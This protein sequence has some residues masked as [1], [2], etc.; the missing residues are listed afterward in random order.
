MSK[1]LRFILPCLAL[2]LAVFVEAQPDVPSA[3]T[4]KRMIN[5]MNRLSEFGND[6]AYKVGKK[7]NLPND[8]MQEVEITTSMLST[9]PDGNASS[10]PTV[11][12]SVRGRHHIPFTL[13]DGGISP[14][15][16]KGLIPL[17]RIGTMGL[18]TDAKVSEELRRA[19]VE[20]IRQV[21]AE[22]PGGILKVGDEAMTLGDAQELVA[23]LEQ[24]D[25]E[26]DQTNARLRQENVATLS[27]DQ[28]QL[29]I[30]FY[31]HT[32]LRQAL[33]DRQSASVDFHESYSPEWIA[34]SFSSYHQLAKKWIGQGQL[35]YLYG[36]ATAPKRLIASVVPI[37]RIG[38]WGIWATPDAP[39]GDNDKLIAAFRTALQDEDFREQA[40][41]LGIDQFGGPDELRQLVA[42]ASESALPAAPMAAT[43]VKSVAA[44]P[45][46]APAAAPVVDRRG[47]P[48]PTT[49]APAFAAS[50][51]AAPPRLMNSGGTSGFASS[52]G[53]IG[54]IVSPEILKRY[55]PE[56]DRVQSARLAKLA[57]QE[58]A[59]HAKTP[60]PSKDSLR[61]RR[62]AAY[63]L[64]QEQQ[65]QRAK[66]LADWMQSERNKATLLRNKQI[67]A[68]DQQTA[69]ENAEVQA[70]GAATV[71][72]IDYNGAPRV[73][74]RNNTSVWLIV[75][76][77][78]AGTVGTESR[79]SSWSATVASES[80]TTTILPLYGDDDCREHHY[81]VTPFNVRW[82]KF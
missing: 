25:R 60:A 82:H 22:Q 40:S 59:R 75:E 71:N 4:I 61:Q 74:I 52:E 16:R 66:E 18:Y 79:N 27:S 77:D 29:K 63:R 8:P 53:G 11:F 30:V 38:S 32:S 28:R 78:Y 3:E 37:A 73:V 46:P 70:P 62:E 56:L 51:S 19:T 47:P 69:K 31:F 17:M 23:M 33:G 12:E 26:R 76:W 35:T 48:L 44:K 80:T 5:R 55:K 1:T 24:H 36:P 14:R 15:F 9:N 72:I 43:P 20:S 42:S 6:L 57:A 49:P 45:A 54:C 68:Q 39:A 58:K 41:L 2:G 10:V 50:S 34:G 13:I 67:Q 65:R 64:W 21:A 81:N 7:H